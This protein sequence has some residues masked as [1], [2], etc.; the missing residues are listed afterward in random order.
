[1]LGSRHPPTINLPSQFQHK[2]KGST[3]R[4]AGP[5]YK[6]FTNSSATRTM[7]AR[8][9]FEAIDAFS[10]IQSS[11]QNLNSKF[12]KDFPLLANERSSQCGRKATSSAKL[13]I[14]AL[15]GDT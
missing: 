4:S 14:K 7:V 13:K 15:P 1:M 8:T 10:S 3:F 9:T 6:E 5:D 11:A 12:L 2:G